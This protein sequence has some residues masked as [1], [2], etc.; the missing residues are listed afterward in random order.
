MNETCTSS[1]QAL[2][3]A[4]V[5]FDLESARVSVAQLVNGVGR[6]GA[7]LGDNE[8]YGLLGMLMQKRWFDVAD[9]LADALAQSPAAGAEVRRRCAQI[10][11]ERG[12][13]SAALRILLALRKARMGNQAEV[14]GH[15]GRIRKQQYV[16]S[17]EQGAPEE[18]LLALATQTY[19]AAYDED[20]PNRLW[21]G[22]NAVALLRL[23]EE[24]SAPAPAVPESATALA[25][26]IRDRCNAS[27]AAR[28]ATPYDYATAAEAELA[29]GN[30]EAAREWL[31]R[32]VPV[33]DAFSLGATLR[34][35]EQIW[36]LQDW[37]GTCPQLLDL[38]RAQSVETT[39]ATVTLSSKEIARTL[40]TPR[41]QAEAVFGADR[42]DSFEN[43]RRGLE[44]S[45]CVARIGRTTDTGVGTGFIVPGRLIAEGLGERFVLV[46]NAHVISESDA[47]RKEG[48]LHPS[49][50][51]VTFAALPGA[52]ADQEFTV[53][54]A[55]YSSAP[56]ALDVTVCELHEPV[57]Q[58]AAYPI[59]PVL[60]TRDSHVQ[61]RVIGHPSGRGLSFSVNELLDH[62]DPRVHYRTA[63]EGGSSGSPVF[64]HEWKLIALHH[65]GGQSVPKL[66]G[67]D[68]SY[69]ANEGIW[70]GA[71]RKAASGVLA[72]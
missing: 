33:A 10:M 12:R 50:A 3:S 26:E 58:A 6:P 39:N 24:R 7:S 38:L 16:E 53:A 25:T 2:Q 8:A 68:G 61:V 42:F 34:Q 44:R 64:N 17:V 9:P 19:F 30:C 37:P 43:Y 40:N 41:A 36:K 20:R 18:R 28:T 21:H 4:V 29:L 51:V 11:L 55:L 49:E 1:S 52:A 15:I 60:P 22:I 13:Y 65:A 45:A 56:E 47:E 70:F 62:E 54:R 48:A 32:Y 35:F 57:P 72:R 31:L 66:N 23:A 5:E 69:Q 14:L 67:R 27:Y 63:T 46:T 59:A 71:I